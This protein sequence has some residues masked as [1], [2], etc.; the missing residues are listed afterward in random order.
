MQKKQM[1]VSFVY[2]F[3]KLSFVNFYGL[4]CFEIFKGRCLLLQGLT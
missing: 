1:Q 4:E 2:F 3:N